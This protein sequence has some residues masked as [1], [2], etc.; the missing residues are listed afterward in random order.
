MRRNKIVVRL[1]SAK[2]RAGLDESLSQLVVRY[3]DGDP[4]IMGDWDN[5]YRGDDETIVFEIGHDPRIQAI[6]DLGE[7]TILWGESDY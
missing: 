5:S 3:E 4:V 1:H 6:A 7:W 2:A